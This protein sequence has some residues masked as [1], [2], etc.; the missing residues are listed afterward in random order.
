[1]A[2]PWD[3]TVTVD[4]GVASPYSP[5]SDGDSVTTPSISSVSR[6]DSSASASPESAATACGAVIRQPSLPRASWMSSCPFTARATP[7][8]FALSRVKTFCLT[9]PVSASSGRFSSTR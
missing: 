6:V 7:S 9:F 8:T 3:R 2:E 4:R 1:M 5:R